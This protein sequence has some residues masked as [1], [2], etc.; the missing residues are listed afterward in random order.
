MNEINTIFYYVK[1]SIKLAILKNYWV[2]SSIE[3]ISL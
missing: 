3:I 1:L 2:L